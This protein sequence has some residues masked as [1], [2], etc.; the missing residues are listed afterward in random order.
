MDDAY[1]MVTVH[2]AAAQMQ[3]E[4]KVQILN[5]D[6]ATEVKTYTVEGYAKTVLANAEMSQYHQVVK[7]MLNYGAAAQVY[8]QYNH[9]GTLPNA[10]ITGFGDEAIPTEAVTEQIAAGTVDGIRFYGAS[11]VYRERIAVRLYFVLVSGNIEDYVFKS[12]DITLTPVCKDA[13]SGLYYVE[14]ANI[15]PNELD[16]AVNCSVSKA[17]Q[18]LQVQYAPLDYIIRMN[19]KETSSA[20]LT[21]LLK[22]LYNY[23]LTAKGLNP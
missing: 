5:G 4:I 9:E 2:V 15:L 19:S 3:D 18:S 13:E 10:D 1:Y 14:F 20:E 6:E 22:A 23:H 7:D 17:D 21:N 12:G 11:L 16:T 8:F